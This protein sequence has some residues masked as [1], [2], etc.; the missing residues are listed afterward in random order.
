[1]SKTN[2]KALLPALFVVMLFLLASVPMQPV[3]AAGDYWVERAPMPTASAYAGA[4]TVKGEI[5]VILPDST[6]LY[7][8]P[9]DTW[10]SKN[11]MP[12]VQYGFAVA[13]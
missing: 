2:K 10:A 13:T 12:T 1:M 3:K 6:Y 7:D 5:Y 4:V 9:T 11:S 8:L